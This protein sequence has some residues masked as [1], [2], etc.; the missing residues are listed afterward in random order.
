MTTDR[1]V[2]L[3]QRRGFQVLVYGVLALLPLNAALLA[4]LTVWGVQGRANDRAQIEAIQQERIA[5][6]RNACEETNQRHDATIAALDARFDQLKAGASLAER[7]QLQ[8][9]RDFTVS[10]IDALAPTHDCAARVREQT[11]SS[12]NP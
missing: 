5:N 7:Q 8:A 10:L 6:I 9:S 1:E 4:V 2:P 11:A 12:R 3:V